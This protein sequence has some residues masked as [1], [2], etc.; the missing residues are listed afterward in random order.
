MSVQASAWA[1]SLRG[2]PSHLKLTLLAIAD[3]CNSDGYG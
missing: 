1:W 3:A 2:L